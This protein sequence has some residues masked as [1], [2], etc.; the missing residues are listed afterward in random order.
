M[1][2]IAGILDFTPDAPIE[3][4]C[5]HAMARALEPLGPDGLEMR[6][7][8]FGCMVFQTCHITPESR[9]IRQPLAAAGGLLLTWDGRLDNRQEL[10]EHLGRHLEAERFEVVMNKIGDGH[11]QMVASLAASLSN[12]PLTP[13]AHAVTAWA[14]FMNQLTCQRASHATHR[15]CA[16]SAD[17]CGR[18]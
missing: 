10:L 18:V 5:L 2:G 1:S 15:R 6:R 11:R 9:R 13:E 3:D 17:A 7:H 12:M 16:S 8:A 4:R 14:S